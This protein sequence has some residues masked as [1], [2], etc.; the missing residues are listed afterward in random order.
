LFEDLDLQPFDFC[1]V[2][3]RTHITVVTN[4]LM[5][6]NLPVVK[7]TITAGQIDTDVA[8][9]AALE[10]ICII[11]HIDLSNVASTIMRLS[12]H[13]ARYYDELIGRVFAEVSAE[14]IRLSSKVC[15]MSR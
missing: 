2:H 14:Q 11:D 15:K 9:I 5:Q 8:V 3:S 12:A 1:E 13:P 7:R 6:P 4:L 10:R